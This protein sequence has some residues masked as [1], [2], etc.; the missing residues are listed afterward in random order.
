MYDPEQFAIISETGD[1]L[2]GRLQNPEIAA[3][4]P[5]EGYDLVMELVKVNRDE[6]EELAVGYY[7]ADHKSRLLFWL[8]EFDAWK[9]CSDIT[10]VVSM[11]HL[12]KY[13]LCAFES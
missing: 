11:S 9:I 5:K 12:R 8:E 10:A 6:C 13:S 1:Q 2:M 3:E 7:F 4:L